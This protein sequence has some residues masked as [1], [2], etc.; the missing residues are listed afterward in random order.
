MVGPSR[1]GICFARLTIAVWAV[2]AKTSPHVLSPELYALHL[3]THFVTKYPHIHKAFITV[4]QLKWSR[5]PVEGAPH[6]HSF[7]RDGEEKIVVNAEIDGTSGKD[8]ISAKL[9]S[10]IKD[11]LGRLKVHARTTWR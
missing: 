1:V 10:G 3:G 4:E 9:E 7:V 11:L 5:I 8:K 6:K 2:I